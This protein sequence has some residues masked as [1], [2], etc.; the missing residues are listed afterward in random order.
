MSLGRG[1]ENLAS[2][3]N[4]PNKDRSHS[5]SPSANSNFVI[6]SSMP[7]GTIISSAD[8]YSWKLKKDYDGTI[9]AVYCVHV[10]LK[11]GFKWIVERRYSQFRDLRRE[12]L[13]IKPELK[14]LPFPPK[15][16]LFN[17]SKSALDARQKTLN[18][19]LSEL[20]SMT[21][22]MLELCKPDI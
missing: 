6:D 10:S 14:P 2:R 8:I 18:I 22:Q 4:Y 16:Y 20:I 15:Y 13:R 11:C 9:Y 5:E 3:Y 17:L 19:Y 12:I 21:P 1:S 7:D